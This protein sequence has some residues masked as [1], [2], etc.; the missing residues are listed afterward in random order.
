MSIRY[1]L[2]ALLSAGPRC[3]PQLREE[4]EARPGEVRPPDADQ[5]SAVLQ[6]LERDGLVVSGEA[7]A[8]G[9]PP[10]FRITADG[11]RE[12]AGWLR[13][14]PDLAVSPHAELTAKILVALR[15]PGTDVH[16]V[17]QAHRRH[18]VELMRQWTR[19][20]QG[21]A[22]HNLGLALAIQAE[23]FRLDSVIRWLDDADGRL[24][25][26][27]ASPPP[28]PA[29]P[30][31][32][33]TAGVPPGRTSQPE[34]S[35]TTDARIR[36]SDADRE[37]VTARLRDHYAEGRLTHAE[38]DERMTA[39]LTARTFGD[40]REIMA[41]LPG[42]APALQ[43]ARPL[44]P[45]AAR[46]A[47]LGRRSL[48]LLPLAALALGVLLIPDTGWP[49]RAVFQGVLLACAAAIIATARK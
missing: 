9:P 47:G 17:V 7:G 21:R 8:G 4:L 32:R 39:A 6:R 18:L 34:T 46:R 13:T 16:E 29:W 2:L 40:L 36:T 31:S 24:K 35:R 26:A 14:P 27:A 42:P 19:A 22:D 43:Q 45:A 41:D 30:G 15:V 48:P 10:G 44:P 38:L 3:G 12:L 11:E 20:K 5:V 28:G 25:C 23:L 49:F 1:A 37:H 33:V